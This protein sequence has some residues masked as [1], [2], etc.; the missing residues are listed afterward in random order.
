MVNLLEKTK[1]KDPKI[2]TIILAI[3]VLAVSVFAWLILKRA[4]YTTNVSI[5]FE[6]LKNFSDWFWIKAGWPA[7]A[8]AALCSSLITYLIAVKS[9]WIVFFTGL[10]VSAGFL[11]VFFTDNQLAMMFYFGLA[12]FLV[13]TLVITDGI[14]QKEQRERVSFK[15]KPL[16]QKG[17]S[18]IVFCLVIMLSALY[19]F[20]PL[21]SSLKK[22][23]VPD[24]LI[25]EAIKA[26]SK[27]SDTSQEKTLDMQ[28]FVK[29]YFKNNMPEAEGI[30]DDEMINNV[31]K[32]IPGANNISL[33]NASSSIMKDIKSQVN[34]QMD[35]IFDKYKQYF[36]AL[37]TISF[38][39]MLKFLSAEFSWIVVIFTTLLVKLCFALGLFEK[40]IETV[41]K[42]NLVF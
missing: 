3:I 7:I 42:E 10:A 11:F 28:H 32:G 25:E 27:I 22:I 21:S 37:L 26:A 36:P 17:L 34:K 33:N 13:L 14:I 8:L 39:L 41:E 31:I 6:S 20:S 23:S 35:F 18:P 19:Y 12:A 15:A 38:F 40:E 9:R 1:T 5:S 4:F 2:K 16:V 24:N 29:D 30:I